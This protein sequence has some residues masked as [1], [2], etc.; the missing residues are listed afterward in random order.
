MR[1]LNHQFISILSRT[2][3]PN[4]VLEASLK[5]SY[6]SNKHEMGALDSRANPLKEVSI[7][8]Y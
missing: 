4:E 1:N 6:F 2:K 7:I 3:I 5:L 8:K